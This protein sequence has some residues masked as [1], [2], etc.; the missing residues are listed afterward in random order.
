MSI[1][2]D[3]LKVIIVTALIRVVTYLIYIAYMKYS[4]D[5]G[6]DFSFANILGAWRKWDSEAY[7]VLAENG[8]SYYQENG[9]HLYLVFLPLYPWI[10]RLFALLFRS[11]ELSGLLVS[12]IAI[13]CCCVFLYLI[14]EEDYGKEAAFCAVCALSL[15]P[16]AFFLNGIM[17]DS[18]FVALVCAFMYYLRK[19]RYLAVTLCG[20]LA[21]LCRL[22]G[23][24]LAF[25]IVVELW[26]ETVKTYGKPVMTAVKEKAFRKQVFHNF[27][28][29]GIKCM[30]MLFGM[31]IY[32]FINL[33][34]EG[35]PFAFLQYQEEHWTH[36]MGPFWNCLKDMCRYI[37][38][39]PAGE[40]SISI[41]WPQMILFGV[42]L[43]FVIYCIY[44]KMKPSYVT[45]FVI[46]FILTYS[47]TWLLS[48]GRYTLSVAPLFMGIGVFLSKHKVGKW[49]WYVLSFALMVTYM[50]RF[51]N[52][53]S[54]M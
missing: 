45:I 12:F 48:G 21:C 32:L 10:V 31:V 20:F 41:W 39:D 7:L 28:L 15:F 26:G 5:H 50:W 51:Y 46:F 3:V 13:L 6:L 29:P 52:Y 2:R 40:L 42:Q 30:P 34:V 47:S 36:T 33:R 4:P 9:Q 22:Q 18:L 37:K 24:F 44:I 25:G 27:I 53:M 11:Y 8:Y 19:H 38:E 54:I 43:I 23:W 1:R 17:T 16:F 49:I 35:N 14:V